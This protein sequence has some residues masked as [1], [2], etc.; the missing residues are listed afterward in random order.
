MWPAPL[1]RYPQPQSP[2]PPFACRLEYL[3]YTQDLKIPFERNGAAI[4]Q[5]PFKWVRIENSKN[6]FSIIAPD[7]ISECGCAPG[8]GVDVGSELWV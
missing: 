5:N 8:V 2:D 7:P 4:A 6:G 3:G 1:H